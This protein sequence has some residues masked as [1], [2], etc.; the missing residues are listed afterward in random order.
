[1]I[2]RLGKIIT[3]VAAL[4]GV[5]TIVVKLSNPDYDLIVAGK[6]LSEQRVSLRIFNGGQKEV[7]N[8][9]VE[10]LGCRG[11]YHI[12][13]PNSFEEG[14]QDGFHL[15]PLRPSNHYPIVIT[16]K[17]DSSSQLSEVIKIT[18][19]NGHEKVDFTKS[20]EED[21]VPL[22]AHLS[23]YLFPI[24]LVVVVA[25]IIL[26]M[27]RLL[28]LNS[29]PGKYIKDIDE[30]IRKWEDFRDDCKD[31]DLTSME[32]NQGDPFSQPVSVFGTRAPL[33][34][35]YVLKSE[36]LSRFGALKDRTVQIISLLNENYS[37]FDQYLKQAESGFFVFRFNSP[38][39]GQDYAS[40]KIDN[41]ISCLQNVRNTINNK[42]YKAKK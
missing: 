6:Q 33:P 30:Q 17:C 41:Q 26:F 16:A 19:A 11:K 40:Q 31:S 4:L 18:H 13:R 32:P 12:K 37:G 36:P 8:L 7:T 5:V 2:E 1:M 27:V 20:T 28:N 3:T 9:V 15:D 22:R 39:E 25:A 29:I 35:E 42:V 21:P 24:T 10:L 14:F 38:W 23:K 34:P